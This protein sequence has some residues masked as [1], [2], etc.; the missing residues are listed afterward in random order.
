MRTLLQTSDIVEAICKAIDICRCDR[1]S[2]FMKKKYEGKIC[3]HC[4]GRIQP[5]S[6]FE[7][8]DNCGALNVPW[9]ATDILWDRICSDNKKLILCP[10][11]F[12][13][14]ATNILAPNEGIG[15]DAKIFYR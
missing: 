7:T 15:F 8:C 9:S 2:V 4:D 6:D 5:Y 11:C 12:M 10:M 1:W 13:K 14:K 3:A